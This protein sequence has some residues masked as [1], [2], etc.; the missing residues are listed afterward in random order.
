[1][2][3]LET[4][5]HAPHTPNS[6]KPSFSPER[7]A[8]PAKFGEGL[9][10]Q[11]DLFQK[12]A[13]Q[14]HAFSDSFILR[15][16]NNDFE[17]GGNKNIGPKGYLDKYLSDPSDKTFMADSET[18]ADFHDQLTGL[19]ERHLNV[20]APDATD[21]QI[22]LLA[23]SKND[24]L[25]HIKRRNTDVRE[26]IQDVYNGKTN[27]INT[28]QLSYKGF[29]V[30]GQNGK[31]YSLLEESLPGTTRANMKVQEGLE[32]NFIHWHSSELMKAKQRG[33]APSLDR[34]IYL[35]PQSK[36]AVEV[37]DKI[38]S[39]A[40]QANIPM[41]G[42]IMDRSSEAI[43]MHNLADD[44][45]VNRGDGIV[46]VTNEGN[47]N[48]L[49]SLV[50][51]I[52]QD[53]PN[54]F[55]NRA[56]S[57]VP[58]RIADGIAIGVEPKQPGEALSLTD[59]A[60][61]ILDEAR[62]ST[63]DQLN[64]QLQY[65]TIPPGQESLAIDLFRDAFEKSSQNYGA[66]PNNIAF[67]APEAQTTATPNIPLPIQPNVQT[68]S[69]TPEQQPNT[70]PPAVEVPSQRVS[71]E[72]IPQGE[73]NLE[74][75]KSEY[76]ERL[77]AMNSKELLTEFHQLLTEFNELT[78]SKRSRSPEVPAPQTTPEATPV[79][80]ENWFSQTQNIAEHP[81]P[82]LN[83]LRSPYA[84]IISNRQENLQTPRGR[85]KLLLWG[86]LGNVAT[87]VFKLTRRMVSTR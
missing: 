40:E 31:N 69:V 67:N 83:R 35:N 73:N 46:L 39:A 16:I 55:A 17:M 18:V 6:F 21:A 30:M 13:E 49:L 77:D 58:Y 81:D 61:R 37:F 84:E 45:K 53:N 25:R 82:W 12:S 22:Q 75:N 23:T 14:N 60:L 72:T 9:V 47:S 70:T 8:P 50:E 52:Y 48:E 11:E 5:P 20:Y 87:S 71:T 59:R 32:G 78:K 26:G 3:P 41:I 65:D 1:M 56:V 29:N 38:I 85:R 44:S 64:L 19:L 33:E 57:K 24:F 28:A 15:T 36:E 54:A 63:R 74:T 34:R 66:N 4:G 51:A 86:L 79:S 43:A 10:E 62:Q 42:K 7:Q 27:R 76:R 2:P 68:A 80:S